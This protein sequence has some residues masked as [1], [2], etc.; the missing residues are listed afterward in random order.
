MPREINRCAPSPGQVDVPTA[1]Q[2]QSAPTP[3]VADNRPDALQRNA[4]GSAAPSAPQASP[5]IEDTAPEPET[6]TDNA[7][8]GSL[9]AS[10]L[11]GWT[12]SI[13]GEV[14]RDAALF[15]VTLLALGT[16]LARGARISD[17]AATIAA[18]MF[19]DFGS[20]FLER[21]TGAVRSTVNG[22][23]LVSVGEGAIIGVGYAIAGVP[24]P[25]LFATFTIVLALVPFGAWLAFGLAALILVGSG[26]ILAG[27]LLFVFS[28]IVMTTGDNVVQPAVIGGTVE[29]PFLLA[30]LGAFGGL[31]ELGLVGLFIGP[32]V[33]AAL[34]LICAEWL[35]PRPRQGG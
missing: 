10:S 5:S 2:G 8:L 21:M 4:P 30:L 1:S 17:H 6:S 26:S 28:A 25:L 14:A 3:P 19:G 33:M 7:A 9:N 16:L 13:G 15:L 18:R 29:L 27:T 34:L 35:R 23:L 31:A 22:T 11:L 12:R 24:Q 20:D 32:V